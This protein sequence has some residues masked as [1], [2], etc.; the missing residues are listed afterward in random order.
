MMK[1]IKEY[2]LELGSIPFSERDDEVVYLATSINP[3][4]DRF[5]RRY[6]EELEEIFA[7]EYLKFRYESFRNRLPLMA[8]SEPVEPTMACRACKSKNDAYRAFHLDLSALRYE[9]QMLQ[10]FKDVA[11]AYSRREAIDY[12]QEARDKETQEML[13]EMERLARAL[14]LKGV[15]TDL[16]DK[17]LTSL[18]QPV[19]MRVCPSGLLEFPEL[20][21][22]QL[23]LNPAEKALYFL[24][25]NHPEGILPDAVV[26]NRSELIRL[27][28]R[29]S[30]FGDWKA[31]EDVVDTICAEDK[32]VLYSNIS[33]IKSK[34]THLLGERRAS[35]YII[36]KAEDGV[37]KISLPQEMV[38]W[39]GITWK[40]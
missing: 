5:V 11:K 4:L 1:M 16:F 40:L 27:Y 15:K 9:G 13:Q 29:A 6:Q 32:N 21:G 28:D 34:F 38:E 31:P 26:G 2:E 35:Y 12:K 17:M 30:R 25:L 36:K 19:R 20:G 10:Q 33:K 7:A 8:V 22:M 37:Y 3:E 18:E 39:S 23:R 24:F 14:K